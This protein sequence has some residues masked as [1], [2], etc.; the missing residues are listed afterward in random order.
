MPI[1]IAA[2][3]PGLTFGPLEYLHP[4]T[5]Q[6]TPHLSASALSHT[7]PRP[8]SRSAGPPP[9]RI[10]SAPT[11]NFF[12]S[13]DLDFLTTLI[14]GFPFVTASRFCNQAPREMTLF[15]TLH[16]RTVPA[17]YRAR[18]VANRNLCLVPPTTIGTVPRR[19]HSSIRSTLLPLLTLGD[20]PPNR[21]PCSVL[22]MKAGVTYRELTGRGLPAIIVT[23]THAC[24]EG[25]IKDHGEMASL[26]E[27]CIL[28]T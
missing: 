28:H 9:A 25:C 18:V 27:S 17:H 16:S 13:V 8:Q 19:Q 2:L 10:G 1:A 5:A 23:L 14:S 6:C 11:Q 26:A 22:Q 20:R 12:P 24:A 3:P 7:S 15:T 4:G 21:D